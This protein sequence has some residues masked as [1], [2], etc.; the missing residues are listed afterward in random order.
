MAVPPEQVNEI[1]QIIQQHLSRETVQNKLKSL[2]PD[3]KVDQG[4]RDTKSALSRSDLVKHLKESGAIDSII[5][6]IEQAKNN[7]CMRGDK[8]VISSDC[9]KKT[10]TDQYDGQLGISSHWEL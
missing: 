2:L 3:L 5:S 4:V 1:K 6:D 10:K 8:V 9:E 7:N